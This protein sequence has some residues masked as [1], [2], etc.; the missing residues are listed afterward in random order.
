MAV[1][2]AMGIWRDRGSPASDS[3][4]F[5]RILVTTRLNPKGLIFALIVIPGRVR[6][7]YLRSVTVTSAASAGSA[8]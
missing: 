1:A 2:V 4:S 7:S 8:W 3:T 5:A 6:L